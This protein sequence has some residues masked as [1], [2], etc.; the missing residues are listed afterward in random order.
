MIVPGTAV[1]KQVILQKSQ[2]IIFN[3]TTIHCGSKPGILTPHRIKSPLFKVLKEK[4]NK[5]GPPS[6][7]IVEFSM[8]LS[9]SLFNG[10]HVS[11]PWDP[12]NAHPLWIKDETIIQ[13]EKGGGETR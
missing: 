11:T 13:T 10:N 8:Q 1:V 7:D 2:M 5:D 4:L 3:E 12:S 6:H 9:F